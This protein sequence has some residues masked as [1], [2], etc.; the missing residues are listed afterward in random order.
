[1]K[2][3]LLV[4]LVLQLVPGY[5][6]AQETSWEDLIERSDELYAQ[7]QYSEAIRLDEEALKV[8]EKRFGPNHPN[9]A[10]SLKELAWIYHD[11]GKNIDFTV[12]NDVLTNLFSSVVILC[13]QVGHDLS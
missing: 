3:L 10:V 1:M 5:G 4:F 2:Q 8:A 11:Q 7:K 9:V 6:S 13:Y 12:G